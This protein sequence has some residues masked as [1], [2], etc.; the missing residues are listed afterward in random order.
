MQ[1]FKNSFAKQILEE[2]RKQIFSGDKEILKYKHDIYN[3]RPIRTRIILGLQLTEKGIIR[4]ITDYE[5]L[6]RKGFK[7]TSITPQNRWMKQQKVQYI[8]APITATYY[9]DYGKI[10][11][12]HHIE[13]DIKN[14]VIRLI[15]QNAGMMETGPWIHL[16]TLRRTRQENE[17]LDITKPHDVFYQI[18]RSFT[19][20]A[21]EELKFQDIEDLPLIVSDDN[22]LICI[23]AGMKNE[24]TIGVV[25]QRGMGK[26]L[27]CHSIIDHMYWKWGTPTGILNDRSRETETWC[28]PWSDDYRKANTDIIYKLALIGERPAPLPCVY[29]HINTSNLK[30]VSHEKEVGHRISI[31]Y[32]TLIEQPD[33]YLKGKKEWD[34]GKS[35][36]YFRNIKDAL[37]EC[38][39]IEQAYDVVENGIDNE[40]SQDMIK[41]VLTDLWNQGFLD[42]QNK[43][44]STW[45]VRDKRT[46]QQEEHHPFVACLTA[47]L[48]PVLITAHL[49]DKGYFP[50][51]F[52]MIGEEILNEQNN[53]Q[54][55]IQ[56][57]FKLQL[58]CDEL[59]SIDRKG[60]RNVATE[61]LGD[62][63]AEGR[64]SRIGFMW[65]SQ[66]PETTTERIAVNTK[67][68]I[69]FRL[70]SDQAKQVQKDFEQTNDFA[71]QITGLRTFEA[72]AVTSDKYIAY[73]VD[74]KA[75]EITD[76]A[77][78]GTTC[79]PLSTHK[80]PT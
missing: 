58:F 26:T 33:H 29:L 45:T 35:L 2:N 25:G 3:I 48:I 37:L 21:E 47:G 63:V 24:P 56:N 39:N 12:E 34:M 4:K 42:I 71:K 14:R 1:P 41:A 54:T 11:K 16:E 6:Q 18:I 60:E 44:P 31:P 75:T 73:D 51:L 23:P 10:P 20:L 67:Y 65:A 68:L 32:K 66:N 5:E 61:I 52:R 55:L 53:N 49:K 8:I 7:I 57:K 76:G 15:G 40:Q 17:I 80:P 77:I 62:I 59:P 9:Q 70:K 64:M 19:G 38:T 78:R 79:W 69:S 74:G 27:T 43:I 30:Y 22:R 36:K 72:V 46:G 28:T 50:Q 13:H